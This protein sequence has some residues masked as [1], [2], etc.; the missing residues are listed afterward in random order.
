MALPD[1]P[2]SFSGGA[3]RV[4]RGVVFFT[5]SMYGGRSKWTERTERVAVD[6][7]AL[8]RPRVVCTLSATGLRPQGRRVCLRAMVHGRRSGR[9]TVDRQSVESGEPCGAGAGRSQGR[10][11]HVRNRVHRGRRILR[12]RGQ[13]NVRRAVE[14]E[15]LDRPPVPNP[16]CRPPLLPGPERVHVAG[17]SLM[18]LDQL[19]LGRGQ[20]RLVGQQR[21]TVS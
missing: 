1:G 12:R 17:R 15:T 19:L 20:R 18:H 6:R 5:A 7:G 11:L 3:G 13:R 14:R 2:D 10:L 8:G 16:V 4:E 21:W 9:C